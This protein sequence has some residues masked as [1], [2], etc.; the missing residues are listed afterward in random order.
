MP[1]AIAYDEAIIDIVATK[2]DLR[3]PNREALAATVR[4]LADGDYEPQTPLVVNHATGVGKTYVMG[5][6]IEYLREMGH[7]NIMVVTPG[8]V[9]QNKTVAN[10][11]KSHRK[12]IGGF[13]VQPDI[14]TPE[15]QRAWRDARDAGQGS[16][17]DTFLGSQIFVFNVQTLLA[18]KPTATVTTGETLAAKQAKIRKFDE[19]RGNLYHHLQSLDDLVIFADES[20]LYGKSAKAFSAAL[21]ELDPAATIGLTASVSAGDDLVYQYPLYRA[22]ADKYVKQPVLVYRR[23]GY[24][25]NT[26]GDERQL[27]DGMAVLRQK[28]SAY[29]RYIRANP[30]AKPV[31]PVMFVTCSDIDHATS[32]AALLRGPGYVGD[33]D[34]VL[35]VDSQHDDDATRSALDNLDAPDSPVRAVVAVSKLREGWDVSNVAV[36]VTLRASGSEILTQ[37]TMGR[38]LRLPFGKYT[39]DP[40]IDQL[41]IIAHTAYRDY[42]KSEDVLK[43]FGLE[44][45]LAP[46]RDLGETRNPGTDIKPGGDGPASGNTDNT[47]DTPHAGSE[48]GGIS[49]KPNQEKENSG[50]TRGNGTSSET[51]AEEPEVGVRVIG[52][53]DTIPGPPPEPEPVTIRINEE[54]RDATFTFP[55]SMMST[56]V[57]SLDLAD[58]TDEDVERAARGAV[59]GTVQLDRDKI[60]TEDNRISTEGLDRIEGGSDPVSD[61]HVH[62]ELVKAALGTRRFDATDKALRLL[63]RRIVDLFMRAARAKD[64]WTEKALDAARDSLVNL[65]TKAADDHYLHG[66]RTRIEIT[67]RTLPIASTFILP[68]KTETE[69]MNGITQS[70]MFNKNTYYR[71]WNR[72]LFDHAQF[73]SYSAEFNFAALVDKDPKVKWWKRLY[74]DDNA[75][76]AWTPRNFYY[77]DFVVCDSDD[78]FWIVEGKSDRDADTDEV[79]QKRNAAELVMRELAADDRFDGV[80]WGYLL[81]TES[82][83]NAAESWDELKKR[84]NPVQS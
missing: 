58:I 17:A 31:N 53:T 26:A 10:F 56:H 43:D 70:T 15:N 59:A 55:S 78:N 32:V 51:S 1:L 23:H 33:A 66:V 30:A 83:I 9:I 11:T 71:S 21:Q 24:E 39:D 65:I 68:H 22:I 64:T 34:A 7:R 41:D 48:T 72:G 76:F 81:A 67:P 60:V 5:A 18:P 47:N 38:G 49:S 75:S 73:D 62:S 45:A 74:R 12:Y 54:F 16:L 79:K 46:D 61:D 82:D 29:R 84:T 3:T 14:I 52:D 8:L 35:Q 4:R 42:L 2:F 28:E 77:P 27:R 36:I 20:H 6:L 63:D 50:S 13:D 44:D 80:R 40:A 19:T 25:K 57:D 69:D 37:Q